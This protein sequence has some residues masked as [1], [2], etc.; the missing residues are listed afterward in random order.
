MPFKTRSIILAL[1]LLSGLGITAAPGESAGAGNYWD[2]P[3]GLPPAEYGNL[4]INR[5]SGRNGEEPV[6]FS[7]W[8][9]RR[10]YT[11]RVCHFE[12]EFNMKVN[13]TEIT[14]AANKAGRYCG[15]C[16]D[17]KE[18]DG[19]VVFGHD[20]PNCDKCHNGNRAYGKEKFSELSPFPKTRFG[21]RIDWVKAL[22]T[23]L[24]KPVY[25]G[26]I[27]PAEITFDKTLSLEAEWFNIPPGG[28]SAQGAHALAR[29]Q[30][31]PP[32]HLQHQEEDDEAFPHDQDTER[33]ILRGMPSERGVPHGRLQA[34]PSGDKRKL[35][36]VPMDPKKLSCK[37]RPEPPATSVAPAGDYLASSRRAGRP[38]S[39]S[40]AKDR[41]GAC[42][43][44]RR[45]HMQSRA[46][47]PN[48]TRYAQ[49]TM[50]RCLSRLT[51]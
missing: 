24:I 2:L 20:K 29:L 19:K 32:G 11:C 15:A 21:N 31:L 22:E 14:E 43:F 34:L 23:G 18:H 46:G 7:H 35:R 5:L 9:H 36:G 47:K 38:L 25:E 13:T 10:K 49:K 8:S 28:L 33:R 44:L 4:L 12:L 26:T 45:R 16:H 48:T 37:R 50:M 1:L 30:Q 3:P 40:A 51:S 17:G 27:K 41:H 42:S 6:T 39:P